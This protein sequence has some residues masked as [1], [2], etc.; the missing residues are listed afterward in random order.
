MVVDHP[1]GT[2]IF[3][4]ERFVVPPVKLA[5][6][7]VAPPHPIARAVDDQGAD[8]TGILSKLDGRYLDTFGRGQ[9]QGLTRDHFVEVELGN[10]VP[11]SGP[12]WLIA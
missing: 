2:E 11:R 6:T 8:V 9:Y 4:D 10:D 1:A 3:T 7:A 12:L 5:I